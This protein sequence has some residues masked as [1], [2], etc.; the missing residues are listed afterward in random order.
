MLTY[1]LLAPRYLR[2]WSSLRPKASQPLVLEPETKL[3]TALAQL[4]NREG[5]GAGRQLQH[6]FKFSFHFL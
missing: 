3:L 1:I 2:N 4:A 6:M 5:L